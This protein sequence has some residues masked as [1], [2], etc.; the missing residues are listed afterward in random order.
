VQT[1]M[2]ANLLFNRI[3]LL[4]VLALCF[5]HE[6]ELLAQQESASSTVLARVNGEN[7]T[8][9]D[10]QFWQLIHQQSD[11]PLSKPQ[12][13][14][15]LDQLINQQLISDFLKHRKIIADPFLIDEHYEHLENLIE[16]RGSQPRDVFEKL[17]LSP[18]DVKTTIRFQVAWQKYCQLAITNDKI[19]QH[20]QA[21]QEQYDG[22][23]LRASQIVVLLSDADDADALQD[24]K[25][26]LTEARQQITSGELT[27]ADAARKYSR[28]PS[29]LNGGDV[30]W[31]PYRGKMPLSFTKVAF[32][33]KPKQISEVVQSPFGLH[34]IQVTDQ[35][36]GDLSL[37]DCRSIIYRDLCQELYNNTAA[38]QQ[39]TA[40]IEYAPTDNRD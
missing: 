7:I 34:L 17:G 13:K 1:N 24:A 4:V 27:F 21:H 28:A 22:T 8:A 40:K 25:A 16:K 23:K 26:T 33:L 32:T 6:T 36:A 3:P 14:Q 31:F 19:R 37:E 30:G 18:A 10:L 35:K 2:L 39:K 38:E 20:Y 29:R 5:R 15:V 11:K 9:G 12:R